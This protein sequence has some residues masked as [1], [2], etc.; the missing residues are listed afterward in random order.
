MKKQTSILNRVLIIAT[1]AKYGG[2]ATILGCALDHINK[3]KKGKYFVFGGVRNVVSTSMLKYF[4]FPTNGISSFLFVMLAAPFLAWFF[5]CKL[6]ISFSNISPY[7]M[8]FKSTAY[9]HQY[10]MVTDGAFMR[11]R[12]YCVY[13]WCIKNF[14]RS[15]DIIVQN[16]IVKEMFHKKFG[17][18]YNV[19]VRWPGIPHMREVLVKNDN[20]VSDERMVLFPV[21]SLSTNKNISLFNTICNNNLNYTFYSFLP[22]Q[23][24]KDN[25]KALGIVNISTVLELIFEAGSMIFT[26]LYETIGL[27]IFE[28]ALTGKNAFVF[29]R[30]YVMWIHEKFPFFK[31]IQFFKDENVCINYKPKLNFSD[32]QIEKV[33]CGEWEFLHN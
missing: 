4:Y 14:M 32:E 8:G 7:P 21:S 11:K 23:L 1:A 18:S 33:L 27:P 28:F 16:I 3:T 22:E 29:D 12:V 26:S 15:N 9:F 2:A 20:T 31:N 10:H 30:P 6:V 19:K 25:H 13:V 5:R 17:D 24:S